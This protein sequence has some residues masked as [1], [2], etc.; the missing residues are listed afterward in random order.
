MDQAKFEKLDTGLILALRA[1]E[2]S[3]SADDADAAISVNLRFQGD[4]APIEALGFEVHSVVKD[5]AL[6]VIRFLDIGEVAAHP[7]VLRISAG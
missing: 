2:E 6:G 4:L 1:Y 7:N 5:Q 3:R